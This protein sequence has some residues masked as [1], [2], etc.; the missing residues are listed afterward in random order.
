IVAG[1]VS[2][3][4][5]ELATV[6]VLDRWI[7]TRT[8]LLGADDAS[9]LLHAVI[10]GPLRED[11]VATLRRDPAFR[12]SL[13]VAAEEQ[14]LAPQKPHSYGRQMQW[15]RW[16]GDDKALAEMEKRILAMT[17]FDT[18]TI[19]EVRRAV[20]DGSKDALHKAMAKASVDR[21]ESM[22]KR[23]ERA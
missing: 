21:A 11:V 1:N 3:A 4:L 16:T 13:D 17:R 12:R 10:A 6:G 14:T 7:K 5:D 23:A 2:S 20:K 22:V 18:S 15:L 8:L 19:E 9:M